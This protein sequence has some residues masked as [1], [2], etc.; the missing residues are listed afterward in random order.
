MCMIPALSRFPAFRAS[1]FA[2]STIRFGKTLSFPCA[3]VVHSPKVHNLALRSLTSKM[4]ALTLSPIDIKKSVTKYGKTNDALLKENLIRTLDS[5][6][7]HFSATDLCVLMDALAKEKYDPLNN[8]TSKLI[9][10]IMDEFLRDDAKKFLSL[11][12][13]PVLVCSQL[14]VTVNLAKIG[15]SQ[16]ACGLLNRAFFPKIVEQFD[17]QKLDAQNVQDYIEFLFDLAQNSHATNY[18]AIKMQMRLAKESLALKLAA[19]LAYVSEKSISCM[20]WESEKKDALQVFDLLEKSIEK[21]DMQNLL[22]SE[23]F[24]R[25]HVQ[26][27]VLLF[28]AFTRAEKSSVILS[29]FVK[30]FFSNI[31]TKNLLARCEDLIPKDLIQVI[32]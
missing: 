23:A 11:N 27:V 32:A 24:L 8:D 19:Q 5:R 16:K 7:Q 25:S 22:Q 14:A 1:R 26:N 10:L 4:Q 29:Q 20:M 3:P 2:L 12:M 15:H 18:P 21:F 6:P 17:K 28:N 31:I 30:T 13:G 9:E